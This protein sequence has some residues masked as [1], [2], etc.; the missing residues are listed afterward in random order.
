MTRQRTAAYE[1]NVHGAKTSYQFAES[2]VAVIGWPLTDLDQIICRVEV[3]FPKKAHHLT[4]CSPTFLKFHLTRARK[5]S[6]FTNLKDL[7]RT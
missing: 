7:N 1:T 6:L 4:L 3:N 2:S 5:A